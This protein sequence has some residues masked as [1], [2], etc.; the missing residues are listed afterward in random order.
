MLKVTRSD[1]VRPSQLVWKSG[2]GAYS[3]VKLIHSDADADADA[4][5]IESRACER[6]CTAKL[7]PTVLCHIA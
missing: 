4:R 2:L 1:L 5:L 6:G 7:T 3:D